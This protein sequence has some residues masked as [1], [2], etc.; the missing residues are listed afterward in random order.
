MRG[1]VKD[2]RNEDYV[3]TARAKGITGVGADPVG[4][5]AWEV[6]V[7]FGVLYG[8]GPATATVRAAAL[9]VMERPFIDAAHKRHRPP[10][11][12]LFLT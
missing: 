12:V 9:S 3:L 10:S 4:F 7:T 11:V 5:G 6:G 2:E 1:G 8:L